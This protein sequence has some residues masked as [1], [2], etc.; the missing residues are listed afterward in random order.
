M[1]H[2]VQN[3]H[4]AQHQMKINQMKCKIF[5]PYLDYPKDEYQYNV[6]SLQ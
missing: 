5:D 2:F 1:D 4:F 6:V 3:R